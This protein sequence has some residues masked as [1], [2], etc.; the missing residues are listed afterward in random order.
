M[1]DAFADDAAVVSAHLRGGCRQGG[2]WRRGA[3]VLGGQPFYGDVSVWGP[4]IPL[5]SQ[6]LEIPACVGGCFLVNSGSFQPLFPLDSLLPAPYS[7]YGK[8]AP[9]VAPGVSLRRAFPSLP[10]V[11]PALLSSRSSQ[12]PPEP[13]GECLLSVTPFNRGASR[14]CGSMVFAFLLMLHRPSVFT[15]VMA[16]SLT[17]GPVRTAAARG[18][19]AAP[20]PA[21][22]PAVGLR[23]RC[24][25]VSVDNTAALGAGPA[26]RRSLSHRVGDPVSAGRCPHTVWRPRRPVLLPVGPHPAVK[27]R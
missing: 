14:R 18:P 7:P 22:V 8:R 24:A 10:S 26:P 20:V 6:F 4:A 23:P 21:V 17:C 13:P 27:L 3:L 1:A 19:H 25:V 12:F 11:R 5:G 9:L 2:S 15:S 16:A